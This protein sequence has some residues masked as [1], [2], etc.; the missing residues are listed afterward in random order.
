MFY[1]QDKLKDIVADMREF[2]EK[3]IPYNVPKGKKENEEDIGI[4]K[5][6]N[7]VVD[8][9]EI[10]AYY[11]ISDFDSHRTE[12][13]QLWG[14]YAPFLPFTLICKLAKEFLGDSHLTLVEMFKDDRKIYCW[15]V[16]VDSDGKPIESPYEVD[17]EECMFEGLNYLYIDPSQ[18]N[19]Y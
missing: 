18:V 11:T 14:V 12:I 5:S 6:R 4:F 13:L 9:Y 2:G 15:T 19:F 8:G 7:I 3:M 17:V 1:K 10:R 16:N